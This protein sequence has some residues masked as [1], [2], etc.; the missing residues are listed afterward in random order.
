MKL[1]PN[2]LA[3]WL[4]NGRF[5]DLS[6]CPV[7]RGHL[8]PTAMRVCSRYFGKVLLLFLFSFGIAGCAAPTLTLPQKLAAPAHIAGEIAATAGDDQTSARIEQMPSPPPSASTRAQMMPK[9]KPQDLSPGDMSP[10][11]VNFENIP[12]TTLI[13]IVY[14]EILKR[15]I[16]L[17]EK[18][19][20]KRDLV[21]FRTPRKMTASEIEGA[22]ELLLQSY[23][24]SVVQVGQMARVVPSGSQAGM[25]ADIR[26]GSS[27]PEA[28]DMLKPIFQLVEMQAVKSAD[29][30]AWLRVLMQGR[31]DVKEDTSRNALLLGGT[32]RDVA[33]A[34]DAIRVLDQPV[35]AGRRSLRI[36][37]QYWT[38]NE[39]AHQLTEILSAEGYAVPP[40]DSKAT[41]AVRYPVLLLPL[42][43]SN[44]LLIFA[45]NEE[46][47]GHV[48]EW[49][50]RLDQ[51]NE[52]AIGK[53]FFIYAA[54]YTSAEQLAKTLGELFKQ[55]SSVRDFMIGPAQGTS[56]SGAGIQGATTSASVAPLRSPTGSSGTTS[57]ASISTRS[58]SVVVDR[59]SNTLIF[60]VDPEEYA[61]LAGLLK[62][63]DKPA[64]AALIEVTVA[65][66][67]LSDDQQLGIEWLLKNVRSGGGTITGGTIGGLS[68]G[69]DGLTIKAITGSGEPRFVLNALASS[70]KATILSSP[71]IMARNGETASIQ[72]G[73]EVPVIT[74][75]QSTLSST[76]PGGT[77]I[78]QT[79]QYRN[80][81]VILS[82]TPIVH[83]GKKIDLKIEQEVSAAQETKTG[84]TSSPT[85][86]TRK[87]QTTLT[88]DHG[89]TVLLGGLISSDASEGDAGIPGLKDIP[90]VGR[91]FGAGGSNANRNELVVLITPYILEN[92]EDMH[93]LTESFQKML[94]WLNSTGS[95]K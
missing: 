61:Q 95:M 89:A 25:L 50:K 45:L 18:T 57:Q 53:G 54:Q 14:T 85:I 75:Q 2:G 37:P 9:A 63:L 49:A 27:L 29:V 70:N 74:S 80:T 12:L 13:Q 16:S 82:V 78:I 77:G 47:L 71:R 40:Q 39:L 21:T 68:L 35:M 87:V 32:G 23:G 60:Q 19:M 33:A 26:R 92:E 8:H 17:D 30:A 79:I 38:V 58:G 59:A 51:P 43:N 41:G 31:L 20:E 52:R 55:Q 67:R 94:P 6:F 34:L 24:L 10:V 73:Q 65:E 81:G 22:M 48:L 83:S 91:L 88:L 72:V 46:I 62:M 42:P 7:L 28:P 44:S 11:S 5:W 1:R 56:I 93:I 3:H 69:T 66:L 76:I 64:K 15:T 90:V 4:A 86:S 84:V 36:T